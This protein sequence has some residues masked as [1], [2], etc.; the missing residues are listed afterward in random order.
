M[1]P[2]PCSRFIINCLGVGVVLL[3][4]YG[5]GRALEVL[6]T[7]RDDAKVAAA[8]D[9][10]GKAWAATISLNRE[11]IQLDQEILAMERKRDGVIAS[12]DRFRKYLSS[13]ADATDRGPDKSG[14]PISLAE[15]ERRISA[16]QAIIEGIEREVET[17]RRHHAHLGKLHLARVAECEDMDHQIAVLVWAV[18]RR[19]AG[20]DGSA[21]RAGEA[22]AS[23]ATALEGR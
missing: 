3:I 21:R 12:Q 14:K 5:P 15:A 23:A 6:E 22:I 1:R 11:V 19:R 9:A 8:K 4:L 10:L 17:K 20:N 16:F 18:S 13:L 2:G 7:A